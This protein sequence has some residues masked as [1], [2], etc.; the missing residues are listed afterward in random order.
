[1]VDKDELRSFKRFLNDATDQEIE[2]RRNELQTIY[3]AAPMKSDAWY[4]ARFMLE[5][6]KEE[7]V[8]RDCLA[9]LASLR[10]SR[11]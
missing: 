11:A 2:R 6:L 1:M 3:D 5:L 10:N 9:R 8:A 7:K 4:D